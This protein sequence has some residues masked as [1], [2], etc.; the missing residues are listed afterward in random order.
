MQYKMCFDFFY[1]FCLTYFSFQEEFGEIL[2]QMNTRLH[3]QYPLILP[4]IN[5]TQNFLDRSS[6]IF[7]YQIE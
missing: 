3:V 1:K 2:S 7:K 6:K 5:E 4:E